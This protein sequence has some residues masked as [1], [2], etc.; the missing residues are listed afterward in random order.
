MQ[1]TIDL[2][3]DLLRRVTARAARE[4]LTLTELIARLVESGLQQAAPPPA[5]AVPRPRWLG[6]GDSPVVIPPRGRRIPSLSNAE[7]EA[8]FQAEDAAHPI[9][10]D[11]HAG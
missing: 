5:A 4:G 9:T 1:I 3:D 7:I 10:G 11:A 6:R 8:L 2:P